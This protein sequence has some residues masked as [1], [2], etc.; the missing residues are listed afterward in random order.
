[1]V[2]YIKRGFTKVE[3]TLSRQEWI[4]IILLLDQVPR[5][6]Y[7]GSSKSYKYDR[8]ARNIVKRAYQYHLHTY[9]TVDELMFLILPLMHSERLQD[10]DLAHLM[11]DEYEIHQHVM[12]YPIREDTHEGNVIKT[13]RYHLF[14]HTKVIERFGRYPKRY[15]KRTQEEEKYMART[16]KRMY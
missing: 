2:D 7:R 12:G 5:H 4:A 8:I 10:H 9:M 15:K 16:A 3:M 11:L 13:T 6:I 1:M 14:E